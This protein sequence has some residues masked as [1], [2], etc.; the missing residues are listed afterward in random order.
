QCGI[1][2]RWGH[3][4]HVCS[5]RLP[6]CAMCANCHSSAVHEQAVQKDSALQVIKCINCRGQHPA[7]SRDCPF[8]TSRFD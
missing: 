3:T 1:C 2:L 4:S 6:W 5:S 8:F 7:I